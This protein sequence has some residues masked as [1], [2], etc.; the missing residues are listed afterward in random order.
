LI[1][2]SL[3]L[4]NFRNY[5]RQEITFSEG[6][7]V[8]TGRNAQGKSN[9]L[10][11][12]YFLSHLRS[13][14]APRLR[15][16]LKDGEERSSVRGTV[17]Q[18]GEQLALKVEFGEKGRSVELNGQKFSSAAKARGVLKCVLFSPEDLYIV[19]GD[20]GRRRELLDETMEELGPV[21][22]SVLNQYRHVLRQRNALLKRWEE[23]GAGLQQAMS[24]WTEALVEAGAAI[25][26]QRARMLEG[27][28][29]ILREA[30]RDIAGEEQELKAGYL[31]KA[32]A[33]G[34][35]EEVSR[36]LME[37]LQGSS[38][39]EKRAR[40]TLVGPHRDDV[41][42]ELGGRRARFAASQGEQ[43]TI[44]FCLR[45]A[46]KRYLNEQTGKMPILLLDDVLSELDEKRR[47]RVL[48]QVGTESQAII[49]T[50]ELPGSLAGAGDTIFVV[51]SGKVTV[52]RS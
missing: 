24:P 52:E 36:A 49:T 35:E 20:P 1:I 47:A 28:A 31:A 12:I 26:V 43:R 21:P 32:A 48:A 8:I 39:E 50:T 23:Q 46:Q 44:A 29:P 14:R 22:A 30:Y 9:L 41:E 4:E 3:L 38:A 19:K 7:N 10:E 18:G 51:D 34:N 5:E 16:L 27:M 25:M 17:I 37:A 15:E 11:S 6:R 45:V 13:N 33:Q 2:K 42:I 40:S